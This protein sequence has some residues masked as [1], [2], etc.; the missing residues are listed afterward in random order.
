M[1]HVLEPLDPSPPPR[2]GRAL[3]TLNYGLIFISIFFAGVPALI[4]VAIAYSQRMR[5]AP[6]LRS[7]FNFQIAMF[8]TAFF[9]ALLAGAL[10]LTGLVM[11]VAELVTASG[12]TLADGFHFADLRVQG[13]IM[14]LMI[15]GVLLAAT[16]AVMLMAGSAFGFVR[17]ASGKA[18][19]K[20]A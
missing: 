20:S 8:W 17:L 4:A 19:G 5:A 1:S 6:L 16:D 10:A 3:A 12:R 15:G 13:D 14:A 2:D 7:H 9:I 11:A 18:L